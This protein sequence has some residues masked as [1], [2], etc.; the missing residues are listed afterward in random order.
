MP[1]VSTDAIV[2]HAFDYLESSRVLRLLTREA[3]VRS[4]VAKGVRKSARRFGGALDLYSQGTAHLYTKPGRDL[5]T[6]AGFEDLRVRLELAADMARFTGAAALAELVLRFARETE[7]DERLFDGLTEAFDGLAAA[8]RGAARE[9]VL[10]GCWRLV[11]HL[12]FAPAVEHCADCHRPLAP[13]D[14]ALFSHPAGGSLCERCGRMARGRQLPPHARLA[15]AAWLAGE[16]VAVTDE[17]SGRAH[18]RLLREFLEEH[19]TDGRPLRAFDVWE[20]GG[21]EGSR[22]PTVPE[23]PAQGGE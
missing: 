18:Q 6:L 13:G 9:A 11:G 4:V 12:G 17:P 22:G 23:H 2:L 8:E 10:A 15:V 20:R 7:A 3:G 5:D 21:W 16:R 1:L 19:L 14:L